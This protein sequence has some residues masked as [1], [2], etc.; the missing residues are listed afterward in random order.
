LR[1]RSGWLERPRGADWIIDTDGEERVGA[2][3]GYVSATVLQP[4]NV[5]TGEIGATHWIGGAQAAL[6]PYGQGLWLGE[7]SALL[8]AAAR[9]SAPCLPARMI[10]TDGVGLAPK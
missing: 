5:R 8:N 9:R 4:E 1:L 10:K 7:T 6:A 2:E 3:Q